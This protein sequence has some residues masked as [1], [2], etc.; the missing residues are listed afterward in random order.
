MSLVKEIIHRLKEK[1]Q[2]VSI[3]ESCTGGGLQHTITKQAGVSAI[4]SGGITAYANDIKVNLLKV[5]ESIIIQHG[6]VSQET[7]LA[8]AKNCRA[9]FSTTWALSTTGIAGPTGGS[10]EKPVGI[11]WIAVAGPHE[12]LTAR[13]Y[14]F[15]DVTRSEH[16][17]KT[18]HHALLML[19]S[20]L[21]ASPHK[22]DVE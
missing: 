9:L 17:K 20:L 13:E 12:I 2:S 8:M 19:R 5:P 3:A 16:R 1:Q 11:V 18:I 6:A 10:P 21:E 22:I 7:A 4:F 15:R 14:S